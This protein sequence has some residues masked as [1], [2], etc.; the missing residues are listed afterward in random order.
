MNHKNDFLIILIYKKIMEKLD[1]YLID[2]LNNNSNQY[3]DL[4]VV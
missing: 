1:N 3:Y 2:Q 4:I